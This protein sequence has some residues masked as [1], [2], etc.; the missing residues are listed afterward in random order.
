MKTRAV[1]LSE[2][3][4][5]QLQIYALRSDSELE[6]HCLVGLCHDYCALPGETGQ[7]NGYNSVKTKHLKHNKA[8]QSTEV[9]FKTSLQNIYI[10]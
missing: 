5:G 2:G 1:D 4:V 7:R 9:N 10:L 6:G 3:L 8:D